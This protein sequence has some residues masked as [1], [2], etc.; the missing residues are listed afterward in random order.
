MFF[1]PLKFWRNI[2]EVWVDLKRKTVIQHKL[3]VQPIILLCV[4]QRFLQTFLPITGFPADVAVIM[5]ICGHITASIEDQAINC[6]LFWNHISGKK[7]SWLVTLTHIYFITHSIRSASGLR[8]IGL[9]PNL[10]NVQII[11]WP[12]KLDYRLKLIKVEQHLAVL[13]TTNALTLVKSYVLFQEI[14]KLSI[15]DRMKV[16]LESELATSQKIDWPFEVMCWKWQFGNIYDLRV[17]K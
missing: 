17:L 9:D 2:G 14:F 12:E 6:T 8:L 4:V 1:L 10:W 7:G 16:A 3:N 11:W 15:M 13:K 5:T